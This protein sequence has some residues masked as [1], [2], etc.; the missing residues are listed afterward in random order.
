M[1]SGFWR[2]SIVASETIWLSSEIAKRWNLFSF[3]VPGAMIFEPRSA[4]R[5]VTRAKASRPLSVNSIVTIG[6]LVFGSVF[7]SGFLMSEPVSSESSSST[8]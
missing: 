5:R 6:S 1:P 4:I 3:G 2:K 8:K 7:A